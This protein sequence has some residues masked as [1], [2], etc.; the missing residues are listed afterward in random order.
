MVT[1]DL[2]LYLRQKLLDARAAKD[3]KTLEELSNTFHILQEAVW[4]VEESSV[5]AGFLE[6]MICAVRDSMMGVEWK[7]EI[8][9]IDDI[10]TRKN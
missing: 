7:S 6:D 9:S 1:T 5:Y 10:R 3:R 8:P 2:L 4:S